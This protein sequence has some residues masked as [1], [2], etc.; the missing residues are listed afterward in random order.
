MQHRG[1]RPPSRHRGV[2]NARTQP[3]DERPGNRIH[4]RVSQHEGKDD[5]GIGLIAHVEVVDQDW[6]D[7]RKGLAVKI[8]DRRPQKE[9]RHE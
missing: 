2:T 7:D 6:G 1:A 5:A 4:N 3:V 9:E 8:I